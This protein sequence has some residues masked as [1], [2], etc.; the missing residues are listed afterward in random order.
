VSSKFA[1]LRIDLNFIHQKGKDGST[2][3]D[4]T[5]FMINQDTFFM[6]YS[7]SIN[8][9]YPFYQIDNDGVLTSIEN[10]TDFGIGA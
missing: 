5:L 8:E 2:E 7:K 1:F 3:D 10:V 4:K 6:R 9:Y